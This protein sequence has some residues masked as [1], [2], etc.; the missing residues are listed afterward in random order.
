MLHPSAL[1]IAVCNSRD[2][3]VRQACALMAQEA[4]EIVDPPR[5]E[6]RAKVVHHYASGTLR[7][8]REIF[9]DRHVVDQPRSSL[10]PRGD[11]K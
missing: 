5:A 7:L 6:P 4:F 1:P 8:R 3:L 11:Q 2:A 10:K 9:D